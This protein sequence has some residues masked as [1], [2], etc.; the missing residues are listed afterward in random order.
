[1]RQLAH[2]S[3]Y[4]KLALLSSLFA[5]PN[6]SNSSSS[7]SNP[8]FEHVCMYSGLGFSVKI[9]LNTAVM[10]DLNYPAR[11]RLLHCVF[12]ENRTL[13]II[14]LYAYIIGKCVQRAV[15]MK[16]IVN[17]AGIVYSFQNFELIALH[18]VV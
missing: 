16:C 10:C 8:C 9:S 18:I 14:R 3:H 12:I 5:P 6:S 17:S 13:Y 7:S 11:K 4:K 15:S 2:R 1:M